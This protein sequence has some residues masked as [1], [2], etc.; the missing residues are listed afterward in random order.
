ME[1]DR[2]IKM[3]EKFTTYVSYLDELYYIRTLDKITYISRDVRNP[4]SHFLYKS[5]SNRIDG[6]SHITT[7]TE[8]HLRSFLP[9][10]IRFLNDKNCNIL[11][12]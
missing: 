6:Y 7:K 5:T 3:S 10:A 9:A 1:V 12:L 11:G 8:R 2:I 4:P